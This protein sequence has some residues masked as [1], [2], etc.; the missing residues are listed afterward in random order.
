MHYIL[1]FLL[2]GHLRMTGIAEIFHLLHKIISIL[3]NMGTVTGKAGT[4]SDRL[5]VYLA[6]K[7]RT[8]MAGKTLN[9][10]LS[11]PL[12]YQQNK[13]SGSENQNRSWNM[14]QQ[15]YLSLPS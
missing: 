2:L 14:K 15:H 8:V 12:N 13:Y 10:G 1:A 5:V 3:G 9:L 7:I 4:D 11:P 6:R